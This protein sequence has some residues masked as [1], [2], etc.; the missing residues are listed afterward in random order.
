M[1]QP[2]DAVVAS[3]GRAMVVLSGGEKVAGDAAL[4][5]TRE[6]MDAG[7]SG[8]IYG[9]NLGQRDHDDSLRFAGQLKLIPRHC[10][11][12]AEKSS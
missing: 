1:Q 10:P 8:V 4:T 11:S 2:V 5:R 3:A 9:C 7:A 6:A 12:S